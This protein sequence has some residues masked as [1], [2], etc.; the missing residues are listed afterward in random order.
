MPPKNLAIITTKKESNTVTAVAIETVNFYHA[1]MKTRNAE[2]CIVRA[3]ATYPNSPIWLHLTS[4][5]WPTANKYSAS[6]SF[7]NP[8]VICLHF[9]RSI[10]NIGVGLVEDGTS[11][12]SGR[13]CV[14]GTCLPLA[15]VSPPVHCPSN[16]LALSCSGHGVNHKL[17]RTNF[18]SML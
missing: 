8:T 4:N 18:Y 5:F 17:V 13:V 12:G 16:N 10:T 1:Q 14:E 15:Q 7:K 11:C 2:F 6:E 3:A 9:F